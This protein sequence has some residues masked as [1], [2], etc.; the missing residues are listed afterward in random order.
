MS[1]LA[2]SSRKLVSQDNCANKMHYKTYR[3]LIIL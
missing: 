2:K 1:Y 3:F